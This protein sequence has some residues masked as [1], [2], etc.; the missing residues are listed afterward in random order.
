[1]NDTPLD[2]V[3]VGAGPAGSICGYSALSMSSKMQVALVDFETFPRDKPCGDAVRCDA[4]SILKELG[5]GAIFD[6]KAVIHRLEYTSPPNFEY[7]EV[8]LADGEVDPMDEVGYYIVERKV[9]DYYLYEAAIKQGVQDYTGH[10]L[11]D[12][13]FDESGRLWDLTL[14]ERSGA[15]IELQSRIL[16]GADGAGSRVRRLAG[17]D[18]NGKQHRAVALRAYAKTENLAENTLRIDWIQSLIPGYGWVFPLAGNEVNVGI[19]LDARDYEHQGR[20]LTSY[21]DEYVLYLSDHDV[22]IQ[23][24][25][26]I[27]SHSLPLAS[28]SVPL[29]PGQQ[30][31]LI[32]DAAAMVNP[33]TGEGIHYGIWAGRS[34]GNAVGQSMNQKASVQVALEN[35]ARAYKKR[36]EK[37][38]EQYEDLRKWVR[39][40][41]FLTSPI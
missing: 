1:M 11:I 3:V 37:A 19:G 18:L 28:I 23:D 10:K 41:K 24:L 38:M 29:V 15:S 39:W 2:M 34:L 25:N 35:Y 13:K 14:Q 20:S 32:G 6:G 36:F 30:V 40:Q 5:L 9:F 27:K 4:A 26:N 16:I 33:F 21:L 7:L 31:A 8:P 17:L 22:V 12:A